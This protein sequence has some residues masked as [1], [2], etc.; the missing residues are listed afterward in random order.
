MARWQVPLRGV[1]LA[2]GSLAALPHAGAQSLYR[3]GSGASTYLSDRPCGTGATLGKL[4]GYGPQAQRAAAPS[5]S[6]QPPVDKAPDH[7]AYLS[8]ACASLNDA[9]RTGP[10][11][12]LKSQALSDLHREYRSKCADD[13]SE[14]MQKLSRKLTDDRN[15]RRSE[16][17]AQQADQTRVTREHDQCQELLRILH[18]KRQRL[19]SMNAGERAGF[20]RSDANYHARC[21]AR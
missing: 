16:Q 3:C 9:I 14:A 4:G 18:G 6:Y 10:A 2:A 11:R 19:G 12:G 17:A 8:P 20:E 5:S 13:E 7:L 21:N 15:T 1:I